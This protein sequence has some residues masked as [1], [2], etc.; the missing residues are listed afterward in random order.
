MHDCVQCEL[1][2]HKLIRSP[3]TEE[4]IDYVTWKAMTV[5]PCTL[6]S[7]PQ[8]SS[9]FSSNHDNRYVRRPSTGDPLITPPLYAPNELENTNAALP[10][11]S[12]PP[13]P[14]PS[15]VQVPPLR[16]FITDLAQKSSLHTGT[17]LATL[18]YLERLRQKLHAVA[19]GM[20]CTCHRVF[21]STLIITAKYVNDTSPKNRH[22]ARYSS[23]FSVD[24]VNL[25]EKQLL[26]LLDFQLNISMDELLQHIEFFLP[27]VG[28]P[29]P[30]PRHR[31][32]MTTAP[33]HPS[34]SRTCRPHRYSAPANIESG[35]L[36]RSDLADKSEEICS[37]AVTPKLS[38]GSSSG[39]EYN[40][41]T[42][43]N[44]APSLPSLSELVSSRPPS[45]HSHCPGIVRRYDA[46][47]LSFTSNNPYRGR[48][49]FEHPQYAM[50]KNCSAKIYGSTVLS[51]TNEPDNVQSSRLR[52]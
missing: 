11:P 24:E 7:R 4:M 18:V 37:D 46:T 43:G 1:S 9:D 40:E 22:W 13:P 51:V 15:Q 38:D 5:I 8:C 48:P 35:N 44:P 2:L 3:I 16:Q 12:A 21:L 23:V 47:A 6:P 41:D 31:S 36:S 29:P 30:F 19:K 26:V 33:N 32:L 34:I 39:D 17:L 50:E 52:R 14:R 28:V 27:K 49:V 45:Y 42:L 20:P 10:P 25:M